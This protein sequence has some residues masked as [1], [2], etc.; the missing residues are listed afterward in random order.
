MNRRLL[1]GAG[2]GAFAS[3]M[4]GVGGA[5]VMI[6]LLLY[7]PPLLAVG[8]LDI[9]MVAGVTMGSGRRSVR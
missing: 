7:V 8:S 9:R 4:V 5:I 3:G 2:V 1:L 6:P